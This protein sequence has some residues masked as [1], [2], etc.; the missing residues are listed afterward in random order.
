MV[1]GEDKEKETEKLVYA[2]R[3]FADG[4]ET[5]FRLNVPAGTKKLVIDPYNTVLRQP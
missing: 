3:V 2:G 4:E 1:K 5:A